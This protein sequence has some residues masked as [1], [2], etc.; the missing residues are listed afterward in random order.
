[1]GSGGRGLRSHAARRNTDDYVAAVVRAMGS[2]VT[3]V[4][5]VT[6]I[7]VG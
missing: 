2:V 3:A 7:D 5:A 1:L 4:I 6:S